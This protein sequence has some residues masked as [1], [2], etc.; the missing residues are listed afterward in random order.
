MIAVLVQTLTFRAGGSFDQ[1][2]DHMLPRSFALGARR[3][4]STVL[5]RTAAFWSLA[6]ILALLL[7]ASS[8]PSP[9]YIVYQAQFGFS[10]ITLTSVFAVYALALLAALVVAGSVSD[11]VGR[12][13]TLLV[14]LGIELVGMLLFAEAQSVGWLFAARSLQGIATGIAMGAISAALLDLAPD[15]KPRLGALLGVAA[16]LGGLAAG[17]L[18]AGLLVQYGPDP[19]RLVFWL[20]FGAFVVAVLAAAAMPETVRRDGPWAHS[21]R[22]SVSVPAHLRVAFVATIPTVMASW[23]LGGLVL[24][25]GP[26]LTAGELGNTSH[27]AGGLPIFIMTGVSSLASIWLRDAHARS[28]ARGGLAALIAGVA[29]SLVALNTGSLALFLAGSAVAGLGF[30]PAFA[31]AFRALSSLAPLDERAGLVSAI[32][33]V[34]YLAFSLPAVAAGAAVTQFG[35]HN[36]TNVY[37]A[38]LIVV[39]TAALALSGQLQ[40]PQ[41]EAAPA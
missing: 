12:R 5:S 23:A 11:H 31:G 8:A 38:A 6:A 27:V 26:S 1:K 17:A 36:T 10:A 15:H 4:P 33:A 20:L 39:A 37:G 34:S 3:S 25:L 9:L 28:T 13:P 32:L 14:A 24:S 2:G 41:S 29:L 18:G 30:G 16:P 19:T 7:F 35:L 40:D 21:L 22:P